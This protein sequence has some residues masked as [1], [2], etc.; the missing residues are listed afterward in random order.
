MGT[1]EGFSGVTFEQRPRGGE[2]MTHF[3]NEN[4]IEGGEWSLQD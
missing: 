3:V 2:A 4:I 1:R